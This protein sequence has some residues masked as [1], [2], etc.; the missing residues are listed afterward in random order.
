MNP[1]FM[2]DLLAKARYDKKYDQVAFFVK[3]LIWNYPDD[4]VDE[5]QRKIDDA[6]VNLQLSGK[7]HKKSK[8]FLKC[9]FKI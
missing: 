4:S 8:K 2:E 7:N 6:H 1:I 3:F 5:W 9:D